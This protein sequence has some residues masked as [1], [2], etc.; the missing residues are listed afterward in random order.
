MDSVRGRVIVSRALT[1][2]QGADAG[3]D[4]VLVTLSV[5]SL[6]LN[7]VTFAGD[8]SVRSASPFW[9]WKTGRPDSEPQGLQPRTLKI[10][11]LS[12]TPSLNAGATAAALLQFATD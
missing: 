11:R 9:G 3:T 5:S 7:R 4:D 12:A 10:D 6:G 1:L 8:D 2:R